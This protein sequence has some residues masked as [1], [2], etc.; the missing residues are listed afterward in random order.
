MPPQPPL[1]PQ[2]FL[3]Q[4]HDRPAKSDTKSIYEPSFRAEDMHTHIFRSPT[5]VCSACP[6][7]TRTR[8]HRMITVHWRVNTC[9]YFLFRHTYPPTKGFCWGCNSG[10]QKGVSFDSS[11]GKIQPI[12]IKLGPG[13]I[14]LRFSSG[15]VPTI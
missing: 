10:L 6:S 7:T 9:E 11:S 15:K 14:Y 4:P 5:R 13:P 8:A 12:R 3:H 1:P 2:R